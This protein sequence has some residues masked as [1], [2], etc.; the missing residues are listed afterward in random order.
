[1]N[2]RKLLKTAVYRAAT[3]VAEG[4]IEDGARAEDVVDTLLAAAVYVSKFSGKG[5]LVLV[6]RLERVIRSTNLAGPED[7]AQLANE[8][9]ATFLFSETPEA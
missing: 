4:A 7:L 9:H 2:L 5:E 8:Q 3:A 1:M 6:N